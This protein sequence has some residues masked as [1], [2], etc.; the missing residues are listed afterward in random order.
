[1]FN[2]Y[3]RSRAIG[4][5]ALALPVGVFAAYAV[6]LIVPEILRVVVPAVVVSLT[7]Q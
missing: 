4:I 7:T 5:A 2:S 1:M 3:R 6:Y